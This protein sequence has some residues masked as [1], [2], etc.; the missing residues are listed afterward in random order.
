MQGLSIQAVSHEKQ[1]LGF[2]CI[3]W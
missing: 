1:L 2:Q 3:Y